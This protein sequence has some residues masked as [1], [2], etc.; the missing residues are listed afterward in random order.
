[1]KLIEIALFG[2]LASPAS[3]AGR[4]LPVPLA[5]IVVTANQVDID[6]GKLAESKTQS[7]DVK[8][9]VPQTTICR[10]SA[11]LSREIDPHSNC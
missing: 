6:A 3:Q 11:V 8:A 1:M 10:S 4:R 5:A 9:Y 7:K 2:A